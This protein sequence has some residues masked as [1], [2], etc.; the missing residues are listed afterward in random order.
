MGASTSTLAELALHC[1]PPALHDDPPSRAHEYWSPLLPQWSP[2]ESS[3]WTAAADEIDEERSPLVAAVVCAAALAGLEP[4]LQDSDADSDSDASV[5]TDADAALQERLD[6]A[7]TVLQCAR[8]LGLAPARLHPPTAEGLALALAAGKPALV[9]TPEATPCVLYGV[10]AEGFR[11]ALFASCEPEHRVVPPADVPYLAGFW[12]LHS[13][14][15]AAA[16]GE[17]G[18]VAAGVDADE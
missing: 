10:C 18:V 16:A 5:C 15:G 6:A 14:V 13:A 8:L 11:A 7:P 4:R 2:R 9:V 1:P 12:L 3:L 17:H